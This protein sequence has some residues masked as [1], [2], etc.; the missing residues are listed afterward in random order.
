MSGCGS[1]KSADM[2]VKGRLFNIA[3]ISTMTVSSWV[4]VTYGLPRVFFRACFVNP[5][6]RSL[7]PPY[8]GARLGMKCHLTFFLSR[9][10]LSVFDVINFSSSYAA[11]RNAEVLSNVIVCGTDFLLENLL[12]ASKKVSTVRSTTETIIIFL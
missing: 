5:I 3:S 11:A 10:S 4:S 8:H 1:V 12:K 7:N 2:Y 6:M 9:A